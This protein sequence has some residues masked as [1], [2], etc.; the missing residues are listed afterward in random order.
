MTTSNT[1]FKVDGI[2]MYAAVQ[3][4]SRHTGNY[5]V[6]LVVTDEVAAELEKLGLSK[7]RDKTGKLKSYEDAGIEGAVFRMK[8]KT[9]TKDGK[10]MMAPR[11]VDSR[12]N[13]LPVNTMIGNGSKVRIYGSAYPYKTPGGTAGIAAGLNTVQVIELVEYSSVDI[14][15]DGYTVGDDIDALPDDAGQTILKSDNSPF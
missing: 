7:A 9:Q 4:P 1:K 5:S 8:R 14:I 11:V 15:E 6:D 13:P 3:H 2:A 10:P 12:G